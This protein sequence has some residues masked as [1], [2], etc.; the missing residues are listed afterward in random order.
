MLA[1]PCAAAPPISPVWTLAQSLI[2]G[3]AGLL[4]V[5]I[6]TIATTINAKRERKIERFK[7]QLQEFYSPM[8]GVRSEMLPEG[9]LTTSSSRSRSWLNGL[10]K[11]L[12]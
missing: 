9:I 8:L 10:T 1:D 5:L 7:T 11:F 6:G 3:G 4:G 2:A 12:F